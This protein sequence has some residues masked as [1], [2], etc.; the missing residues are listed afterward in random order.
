MIEAVGGEIFWSQKVLLSG[1][2]YAKKI[3]R[4]NSIKSTK[5]EKI[6]REFKQTLLTTDYDKLELWINDFLEKNGGSL[7]R[8]LSNEPQ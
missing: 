8:L 7:Q 2:G 1:K 4:L 3:K 6:K 5:S